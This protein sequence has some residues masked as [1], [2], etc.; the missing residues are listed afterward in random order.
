SVL[1]KLSL[2]DFHLQDFPPKDSPYHNYDEAT[3]ALRLIQ[4]S[5]PDI[6]SMFSIGKSVQ[7]RELWAVRFNTD[8]KNLDPSQK[9]GIVFMGAH[10]AREHLS[11]EVPLLL[12]QWLVENRHREDVLKLLNSRDITIIPMVNPDGVEY[13]IAT[14][15]YRWQRKNMRPNPNGTYGVDLNRNYGYQWGT[16]GSSK[17]Q[18]SDVYMGPSPFSEPESQA[19]R[20]FCETH[21]NLTILLSYHT[22]SELILYPWGHTYS[23]IPNTEDL[24]AFTAMAKKM[25]GMTGYKPEQSSDLYIASGDTTDW[26]YGALGIFAFTFELTPSSILKGGFYPGTDVIQSTFQKNIPPAL[27]LIDLADNPRRAISTAF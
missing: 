19:V 15:K 7:G 22:F 14:G 23:S 3:A 26:A 11:T 6:V 10:H 8:A 13:D 27:Y 16:G 1:K 17:N 20:N 12:A 9:P 5:A 21:K 24:A 2:T 18:N 25:A 4:A